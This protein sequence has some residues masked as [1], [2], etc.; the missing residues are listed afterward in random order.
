MGQGREPRRRRP[1]DSLSRSRA[2]AALRSM[3]RR[4][5]PVATPLAPA[6]DARGRGAGH[7]DRLRAAIAPAERSAQ[8]LE[9]LQGGST[10]RARWVLWLRG[11]ADEVRAF[12]RDVEAD[13]RASRMSGEAA[14]AALR[15]YLED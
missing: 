7:G 5:P 6:L 3:S 13:W 2:L 12:A 10:G 1:D 9:P 4:N 15:G 11:R 14:T 8:L